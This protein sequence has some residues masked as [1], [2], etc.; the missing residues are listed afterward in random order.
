ERVGGTAPPPHHRGQ[1]RQP[2]PRDRV[3][4]EPGRQPV[5]AD[6]RILLVRRGLRFRAFGDEDAAHASA[7][8]QLVERGGRFVDALAAADDDHGGHARVHSALQGRPSAAII[9]SAS[10]GPHSPASYNGSARTPDAA[11]ARCTG[12]MSAQESSTK[13][14]R[15]KSVE[16]PSIASSSSVS[17]ASGTAIPNALP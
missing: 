5:D 8:A 10:A 15:A 1:A 12:V 7:V 6:R 14:C 16:S 4:D 9:A 13:S 3:V 17:Y 11:Q 2:Q